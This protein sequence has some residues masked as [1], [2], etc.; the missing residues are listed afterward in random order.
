MR[1]MAA[2][3]GARGRLSTH[4]SA[5]FEGISPTTRTAVGSARFHPED[6][7]ASRQTHPPG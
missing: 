6:G 7:G 2:A 5:G 1:R 4:P 3:I